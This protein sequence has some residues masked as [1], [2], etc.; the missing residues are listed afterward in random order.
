MKKF[1]SDRL[2]S[3][4]PAFEGIHYLIRNEGNAIIHL[5][6]T[7]IVLILSIMLKITS[8]EWVLIILAITLVW[9]AELINTALEKITDIIQPEL[10]PKAKIIKDLAASAVLITAIFSVIIGLLILGPKIY[11]LIN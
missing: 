5:I 3:F 7:V 9:F 10:H 11:Q 4:L 2:K 6:A 8:S 1:F